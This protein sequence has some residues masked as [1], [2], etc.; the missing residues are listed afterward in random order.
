M[1]NEDIA[2]YK[3]ILPKND[4]KSVQ[5]ERHSS[6]SLGALFLKSEIGKKQDDIPRLL[7]CAVDELSTLRFEHIY[8]VALHDTTEAGI[9]HPQLRIYY[10]Y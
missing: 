3:D 8:D 1:D 2:T 6:D 7:D 9:A 4:A 10:T 5:V